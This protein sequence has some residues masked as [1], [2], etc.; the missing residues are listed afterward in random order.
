MQMKYFNLFWL[1]LI[2]ALAYFAPYFLRYH[3]NNSLVII[4]LSVIIIYASCLFWMRTSPL[5][6]SLGLFF[7]SLSVLYVFISRFNYF[8]GN[9]IHIEYYYFEL[10]NKNG[11]LSFDSLYSSCISI[12]I[13]PTIFSAISGLNG[14]FV[15]MFMYPFL[16]SLIP[17]NL[18]MLYRKAIGNSLGYVS[19]L[20]FVASTIYLL[21]M[22]SVCRQIVSLF[23][24][25]LIIHI[26]IESNP[27]RPN[28]V[29]FVVLTFGLITSHYTTG[30]TYVLVLFILLFYLSFHNWSNKPLRL[31]TF[32]LVSVLAIVW[33]GIINYVPFRDLIFSGRNVF[34]NLVAFFEL[35]SRP[36][37]ALELVGIYSRPGL[38]NIFGFW[39]GNVIR[40]FSLIGIVAFFRTK[41]NK[42]FGIK[43]EYAFI[44]LTSI[45]ILVCFVALPYVS[46]LYN[47][48]RIYLNLSVF[49]LPFIPVGIYFV[50]VSL[51]NKKK[52]L[53][54]SLT[55]LFILQMCYAT[56]LIHQFS[57]YP[58]FMVMNTF[59]DATAHYEFSPDIRYY[60]FDEEVVS[61]KWLGKFLP[62][63]R[64]DYIVSDHIGKLIL[65]SQGLIQG[66]IPYRRES[67]L[68]G[69]SIENF[70]FGSCV[71]LRYENWRYHRI[72][73]GGYENVANI[74]SELQN[75]NRVYDNEIS[76]IIQIVGQEVS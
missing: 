23:F 71:Y 68:S 56:G 20:F 16:L 10:T 42:F 30:W 13:L 46:R 38:A 18:Y 28:F 35:E 58:G 37:Y 5:N 50:F 76:E 9:D 17:V 51:L 19:A 25:T 73:F 3:H 2:S 11:F 27:S 8:Y 45:V 62:P 15:F 70:V 60:I 44:G 67:V 74:T 34:L 12:T 55:I 7:I 24:F 29:L 65:S 43:R 32:I 47:L 75:H 33:Y 4:F 63:I 41:V 64:Y 22:P 52:I 57:G 40:G 21:Q 48:D 53:G 1:F 72:W 36:Q 31:C 66:L 59:E 49:L 69:S 61:A 6:H 39:L 14:E 54:V 26:L